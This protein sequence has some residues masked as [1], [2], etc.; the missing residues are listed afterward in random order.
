MKTFK[1][2]VLPVVTSFLLVGCAGDY[3]EYATS[4]ERTN[5]AN[6]A[7]GASYFENQSKLM[8]EVAANLKD[9]ETALVLFAIMSQQNSGEIAKTFKSERPVKPTTGTDVLNTIAGETVPT[10]IQWGA[11]AFIGHEVVKGLT[12]AGKVTVKGDGN[13]M[14][15]KSGN[16]YQDGTA[17]LDASRPDNSGQTHNEYLAPEEPEIPEGEFVPTEPPAEFD[18]LPIDIPE[19][20]AE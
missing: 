11:G 16:A 6:A 18:D 9:N 15:Y 10:L 2:L 12:K 8:K 7:L 20:P 1:G 4:V 13:N 5:T 3:K 17:T 14:N 19:I